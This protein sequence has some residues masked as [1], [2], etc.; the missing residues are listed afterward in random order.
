M[1]AHPWWQ[2]GVV[3]QIYPRSF[4]DSN[5]DGVGDLQGILDR[6]D[7]LAGLGVDAIWISPI[8]PSPMADFGYDVADYTDI[9][10][11]FGDL[12]TFDRLLNAIH[13]RGLK[14]ILDYV[15][16]HTS[17]QHPWFLESRSSRDNPKRDWYIWRDAKPDGSPPN[18]WESFFGGPAWEWDEATGQYYLHLFLKEQPDLNWRNPEVRAAMHDVLRFWLD[19][20]VDGFR[21]DVVP[22]LMKHPDMPDNPPLQKNAYDWDTENKLEHKY[23]INQPEIHERFREFRAIFDSYPGDRVIIGETPTMDVH[24]LASFYG[25]NLDELHM[26]FNFTIQHRPWDARLMRDAIEAYYAALPPGATPNFVLGSHDVHRLATRLGYANH[27]SAAMLLLTL[28]GVPTLYYGDEIGMHDVDI[29]RE[30][31][32]DPWAINMPNVNVG[33]DPERTPMQWDASPNAGFC[34]EGVTPWLPVAE[35]YRTI[36]VA[37]QEADPTSTLA[38]YRRLLALRRATPALHAGD[39]AFVNDLPEGVLAYTRS[40]GDDHLLVVINFSDA[41]R[42]LDLSNVA[43]KGELLLS[44]HFTP[45]QRLD[46]DALSLKAN[47]SMLLRLG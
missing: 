3:Y 38:F 27:R 2:N 24:L 46:L 19:R 34:P 28:R 43:A 6:L 10:P 15:P 26:P 35:D 21:M 45:A 39:F 17:D 4:M 30:L 40:A 14:L 36:N 47:E 42:V 31:W 32:Q 13:E 25:Q 9:H 12:E 20:G 37:A 1:S 41:L 5:G 29:P 23:D 16:N 8:Y 44:T 18:N 33:R 22:F 11:L 7:Y